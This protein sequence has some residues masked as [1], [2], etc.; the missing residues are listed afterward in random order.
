MK[1]M[2]GLATLFIMFSGQAIA[3][4][5]TLKN[6]DRVSGTIVRSDGGKLLVKTDLL[7]DVT[8]D[9]STVISITGEQLVVVTTSDGRT[10]SG[11]LNAT[12][13]KVELRAPNAAVV[14]ID[15]TAI[16][17]IRSQEE[18]IAYERSLNP[19]LLEGWEGGANIGLALTSGNSDT[20]NVGLGLS[21]TRA[22]LRDKTTV[23]GA[24]VYG[25]D[26]TSGD[27]RTTANTIRGGVRYDRNINKKFFGY[28]FTD[29]EHN[30]LQDLKLRFVVGGGLGYHAINKERTQL[31]LLGGLD[32]NREFFSGE[33]NDHSSAE[34]QLGETL[35]HKFNSRVSFQ[36]QL[37]IFPNLSDGGEYRINFDASL[38]A[39]MTKR[40]A[41][42]VTLSDRFLS[43]PPPGFEKNDLILTSGIKVRLGTLK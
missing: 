43:N 42:Q 18:Q 33:N 41:W 36:E 23:T 26:S 12:A 35:F 24:A 27:S 20:T 15:R 25:R 1:K 8:V 40:I 34:V 30:E 32:W 3:D 11:V 31:D 5:I 22:T 9:L 6:G 19:G 21:L 16:Q 28:G 2:A 38:V 29:L 14:T 7:G 4:Q 17:M 13:D 39:D 37:F 10:V